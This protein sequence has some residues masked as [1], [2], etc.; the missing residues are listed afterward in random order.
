MIMRAKQ[1]GDVLIFE[2]EGHL[3]F[4]TTQQFQETCA[5]LVEKHGCRRLV[6]DFGKLKFVGSSG[7]NQFISALKAFNTNK[8]EKPK[9]VRVSPEFDRLIKAYQT[10][11]NP[12]EI[13]ADEHEAIAAFAV[14]KPERKAPSKPKPKPKLKAKPKTKKRLS[15]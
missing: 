3:D 15:N 13:F 10:T 6:F 2:L 7:I 9:L 4:E 1:E 5:S 14:V 8:Q 12:F 11:R